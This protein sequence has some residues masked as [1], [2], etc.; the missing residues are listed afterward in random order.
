MSGSARVFGPGHLALLA[1]AIVPAR[2]TTQVMQPAAVAIAPQLSVE[3]FL[4]AANSRDLYGMGRLFGTPAGPMM[5][6]G[7]TFPLCQRT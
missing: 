1:V 6:T 2:C 4:Q 7:S 5:E 3:R